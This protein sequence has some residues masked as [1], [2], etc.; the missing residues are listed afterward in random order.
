MTER[1]VSENYEPTARTWFAKT[2]NSESRTNGFI[3]KFRVI[4]VGRYDQGR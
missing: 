2:R 1:M 3:L 4:A